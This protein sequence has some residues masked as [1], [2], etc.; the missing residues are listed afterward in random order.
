MHR[1]SMARVLTALAVGITALL[2]WAQPAAAAPGDPQPAPGTFYEIFN[3][4]SPFSPACV[5][6]P[7][8]ST[9]PGARLQAWSCHS[10]SNQLWQFIPQPNGNFEIA[11][12]HSQ[13]C[14][15]LPNTSGANNTP[16]EQ[17]GCFNFLTEQWQARFVFY[18]TLPVYQFVNQE[19]PWLCLALGNGGSAS[20]GTPIVI[21]TCDASVGS[22][23]WSLG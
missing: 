6:V 9:T 2:A 16:V 15:E 14:F 23:L 20:N 19:F 22:D 18:K 10:G 11:N 12:Q 4:F 1:R 5:D 17:A 8:G 7:S 3:A 13:Q 21:S